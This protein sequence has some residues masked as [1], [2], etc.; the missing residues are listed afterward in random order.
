MD[1]LLQGVNLSNLKFNT[2]IDLDKVAKLIPMNIFEDLK[3]NLFEKS[4]IKNDIELSRRFEGEEL[5]QK[6][7]EKN[8]RRMES[9]KYDNFLPS[10]KNMA[11]SNTRVKPVYDSFLRTF[12]SKN[13]ILKKIILN[14]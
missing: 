7:K 14:Q 4:K 10:G 2:P 3:K 12:L 9:F 5:Q 11:K 13:I 1:I 6:K 8:S